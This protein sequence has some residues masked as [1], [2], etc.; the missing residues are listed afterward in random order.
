VKPRDEARR[1]DHEHRHLNDPDDRR[2][3]V[4][5][6]GGRQIGREP[7]HIP[8]SAVRQYATDYREPVAV[9]RD[10]DDTRDG[11]QRQRRDCRDHQPIKRP[12]LRIR[13]RDR[14]GIDHARIL[15]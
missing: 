11:C 13:R 4:A 12:W 6:V 1:R 7:G 8:R 3:I 15:L 2:L 9:K 10:R 5:R 14:R